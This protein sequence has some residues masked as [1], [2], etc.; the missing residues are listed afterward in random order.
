MNSCGKN[1]LLGL[2]ASLARVLCIPAIAQRSTDLISNDP[3]ESA[4]PPQTATTAQTSSGSPSFASSDA[5]LTDKK[6]HFYGT[7]YL[8]IPGIHGTVGIRGFD[9]SV[10]VT[11]GDIFSNFR[12]GLLGAFVPTYNRFSAPVDYMWMRLRDSRAIPFN[13]AYSVQATLNFSI[14]T[15]KVAYLIVNNPKLRVYGTAGPRIWHLGTT[16]DLVPAINGRNLYKGST[17][18]D[19]VAG[20]RFSMPLGSKASADVFGDAGEGGATLDYQVGGFLNYQLKP[21]LSMQGGWRYLTVHYGNDGNL[22]NVSIQGIVLG[23]TYK[24]K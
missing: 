9:T 2:A 11:A 13:P 21:K 20:G 23:A 18:T 5:D 19:F 6:W 16:F 14:V 3:T 4:S 7:G 10:H 8:W 15:P 17:W 22:A 12:G 24:F 1:C